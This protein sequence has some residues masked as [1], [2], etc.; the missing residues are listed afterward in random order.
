MSE[1]SNPTQSEKQPAKNP[2]EM[3][4]ERKNHAPRGLDDVHN[5]NGKLPVQPDHQHNP[6]IRQP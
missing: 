2:A 5:F 6:I 1:P 3:V 4:E